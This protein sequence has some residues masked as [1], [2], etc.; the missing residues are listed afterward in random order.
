MADTANDSDRVIEIARLLDEHK[1]EDTVILNVSGISSWTDYFIICTA[2]SRTHIR[3]L[4]DHLSQ[5]LAK[6]DIESLNSHKNPRDQGWILVD[7]GTFIINLMEKE[8]RDFYEL[9]KL[10]FKAEPLCH[11]SKSS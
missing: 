6:N 11:S 5:Y 9:E 10:W 8:K 2:R 7:C 3:G 4:F 1:A